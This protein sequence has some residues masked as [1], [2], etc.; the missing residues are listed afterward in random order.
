MTKEELDALM[1]RNSHYRTGSSRNLKKRKPTK[2]LR[3]G[4]AILKSMVER[5]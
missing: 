4:I 2:A 1:K 3:D 5:G